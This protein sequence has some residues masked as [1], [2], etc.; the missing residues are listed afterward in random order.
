MGAGEHWKLS[1]DESSEMGAKLAEAFATLPPELIDRFS[2]LWK[3]VPWISLT[4][5]T[6]IITAP[7]IALTKQ[8]AEIQR[9]QAADRSEQAARA[10]PPD[11]MARGYR[12]LDRKLD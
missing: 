2:S 1:D 8:I 12:D 3:A 9:Q 11:M 6:A 4:M 10:M 7:R 5:T